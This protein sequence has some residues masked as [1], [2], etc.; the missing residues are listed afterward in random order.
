MNKILAIAF[1]TESA[2]SEGLTALRD[3][4]REGSVTLYSTAVVAK[5]ALAA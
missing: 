2:A 1:D 5:E 4:H 3:L